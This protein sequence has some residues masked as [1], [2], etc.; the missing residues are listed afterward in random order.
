MI[1]LSVYVPMSE[2]CVCCTCMC[3]YLR[4]ADRFSTLYFMKGIM[5]IFEAF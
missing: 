2:W 3:V 5:S 4:E 1:D